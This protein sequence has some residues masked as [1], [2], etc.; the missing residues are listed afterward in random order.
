VQFNMGGIQVNA[1]EM[2]KRLQVC[3]SPIAIYLSY[4]AHACIQCLSKD[5]GHASTRTD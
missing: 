1:D 4:Y 2:V 3:P 5:F